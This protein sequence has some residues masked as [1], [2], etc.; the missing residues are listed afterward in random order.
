MC[1]VS[2]VTSVSQIYTRKII[3]FDSILTTLSER[4]FLR[5][6]GAVV[7]IGL[8]LKP[9]HHFFKPSLFV[10]IRDTHC[11]QPVSYL[12]YRELV[13]FD[14]KIFLQWQS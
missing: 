10:Q 7:E 6:A 5:A 8:S 12:L 11:T 4:H 14:E 9:N 13:L 1:H 3:I 2:G